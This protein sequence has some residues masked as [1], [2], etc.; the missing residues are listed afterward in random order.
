MP[1]FPLPKD[2]P[3][4][5][6][7][8]ANVLVHI[9]N[10]QDEAVP[11][12][13]HATIQDIGGGLVACEPLREQCNGTVVL[14]SDARDPKTGAPLVRNPAIKPGARVAIPGSKQ[15]PRGKVCCIQEGQDEWVVY[16]ENELLFVLPS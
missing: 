5:R 3:I 9:F 16:S 4:A 8:G 6:L 2:T 13:Q 12:L 14:V 11:S 7:R 15:R 1:Q 10:P